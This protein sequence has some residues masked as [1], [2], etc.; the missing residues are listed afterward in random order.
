MFE[1]LAQSWIILCF[2]RLVVKRQRSAKH[3][4]VSDSR[5]CHL[6]AFSW[7]S[8]R[9]TRADHSGYFSS[10]CSKRR[11]RSSP[12]SYKWG[13]VQRRWLLWGYEK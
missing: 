10:S 7:R 8:Y 9:C 1:K 2:V 13:C 5:H 11:Q 12:T 3:R 6:P 4:S